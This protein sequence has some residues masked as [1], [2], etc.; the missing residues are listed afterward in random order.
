MTMAITNVAVD[1]NIT[2][3]G[4]NNCI[5]GDEGLTNTSVLVQYRTV[6]SIINNSPE[7]ISWLFLAEVTSNQTFVHILNLTLE[8]SAV[9]AV[10][11]RLLQLQHGGWS[12]NCWRVEAVTVGKKLLS[13]TNN[14]CNHTESLNEVPNCLEPL[15]EE[16]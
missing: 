2:H 6:V 10:Q 9:E 5:G 7:I 1:L 8:D 13:L 12:C 15:Q 11:L 4:P 16:L 3:F 14:L